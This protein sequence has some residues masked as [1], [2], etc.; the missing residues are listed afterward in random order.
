MKHDATRAAHSS[1]GYAAFRDTLASIDTYGALERVFMEDSEGNRW[2]YDSGV[3]EVPGTATTSQTAADGT[4]LTTGSESDFTYQPGAASV[5]QIE[6]TTGSGKA[7]LADGDTN[8]ATNRTITDAANSTNQTIAN[9]GSTIRDSVAR[10]DA[11]IVGAI[12][13]SAANQK[14]A[15][16]EAL[17]EHDQAKQQAAEF[18]VNAAIDAATTQAGSGLPSGLGVIAE[19]PTAGVQAGSGDFA[20]SVTMHVG[21]RDITLGIAA[22]EDNPHLHTADQILTAG[23]GLLLFGVIL[24]FMR[25]VSA[26][27]ERYVIGMGNAGGGGGSVVGPENAIP[28]VAQGKSL[29]AAAAIVSATAAAIGVLLGFIDAAASRFGF[30]VTSLFESMDLAV[31]G[32]AY[33]FLDRYIP[34]AAI[35]TLTLLSIAFPYF[36][37]PVYAGAQALARTLK[38]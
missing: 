23:R 28:G 26:S 10:G 19:R 37:L 13:D 20:S 29:A 30:G 33:G 3:V 1:P 27:L 15:F 21:D 38:V 14:Q 4:N 34:I 35:G 16:K 7:P 5:T 11:A 12:N 9:V 22:F 25:S 6:G 36:A 2:S 18:D 32:S 24:W 17:A 31:L 8:A